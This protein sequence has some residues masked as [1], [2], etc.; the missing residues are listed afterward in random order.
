M[1]AE[2]LIAQSAWK[3]LTPLGFLGL[4]GGVFNPGAAIFDGRLFVLARGEAVRLRRLNLVPSAMDDSALPI[5]LDLDDGLDLIRHRVIERRPRHLRWRM[6]D[7][8]LFTYRGALYSNHAMIRRSLLHLF[9][10]YWAARLTRVSGQPGI[11]RVDPETGRLDLLGPIDVDVP[12]ARYE[13][14]WVVFERDGDLF[15]I[16]SL[17]P[18]TVL[19]LVD[20]ERRRFE[21][22]RQATLSFNP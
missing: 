6:E 14:N 7:F 10:P 15:L 22:V 1:S 17:A 5:W 20:W 12:C 2:P 13:K 18:Y 8:R 4:R 3:R 21:T 16:Y 19:R 11:S 9:L